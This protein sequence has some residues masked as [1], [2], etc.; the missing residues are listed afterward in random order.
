MS[1]DDIGRVIRRISHEILETHR[2][3][4]NVVLVGIHTRGVILARML[5]HTIASF[6]DEHVPVGEL[7]IGLYRDDRDF[8]PHIPERQTNIPV[9]IDGK[10]V[11]VVDDVLYTGRTVR[12]ALDALSD[13][14]RATTTELAVLVDRGHR[15][16]PIRADYVGKN[17][18]TSHE[19]RVR[20]RVAETDGAEGVYIERAEVA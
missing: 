17:L 19:Q 2:G 5:A 13:I 18:P 9:P 7:D 20:V 3:A 4:P 15:E 10:H 1:G 12:A 14:G 6:E 11:I 8:R 16:L